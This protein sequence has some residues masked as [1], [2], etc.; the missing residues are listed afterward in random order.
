MEPMSYQ[1]TYHQKKDLLSNIFIIHNRQS[2]NLPWL[3]MSYQLSGFIS[4]WL[5][6]Y[7]LLD[8]LLSHPDKES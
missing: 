3:L 7:V 6:V 2:E 1:S 4:A 8:N 5:A